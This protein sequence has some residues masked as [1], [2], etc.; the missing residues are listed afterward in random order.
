LSGVRDS[1]PMIAAMLI[2]SALCLL[3]SI[4]SSGLDER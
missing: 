4:D 2:G 1:C 3:V